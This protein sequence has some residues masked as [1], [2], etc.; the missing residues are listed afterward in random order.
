MRKV[1]EVTEMEVMTE[2]RDMTGMTVMTGM[3]DTGKK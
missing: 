3:E 2:I 1:A